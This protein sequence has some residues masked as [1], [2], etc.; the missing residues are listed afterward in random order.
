MDLYTK[1]T[2]LNKKFGKL[3]VV[4]PEE[5]VLDEYENIVEQ[6]VYVHCDCGER[7]VLVPVHSLLT[8][9]ITDCGCSNGLARSAGNASIN[10]G[11]LDH[12]DSKRGPYAKLYKLW[13]NR[14]RYARVNGHKIYD[15]WYSWDTF[16]QWAISKGWKEGKNIKSYNGDFT[17][18]ACFVDNY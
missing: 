15:D 4:G 12:G 8:G 10:T 2:F 13:S 11:H 18:E 17:P 6:N 14:R 16:K 9:K 1:D 3:T 7:Y 5:Y